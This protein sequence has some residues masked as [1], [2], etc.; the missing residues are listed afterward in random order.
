MKK[1]EKC[2]ISAK[3]EEKAMTGNETIEKKSVQIAIEEL[4]EKPFG[5]LESRTFIIKKGDFEDEETYV[6]GKVE[7]GERYFNGP[8][9]Y[10]FIGF[11]DNGL[12]WS[13]FISENNMVDFL[14][15]KEW[16]DQAAYEIYRAT[17]QLSCWLDE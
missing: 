14:N 6:L 12:Y 2:Y 8:G 15:N 11:S 16:S 9:P 7:K 1:T 4:R 13:E 5:V 10:Y 3:R 17:P